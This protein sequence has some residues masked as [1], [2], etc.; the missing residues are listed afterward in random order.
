MRS[1]VGEGEGARVGGGEALQVGYYTVLGGTKRR[2]HDQQKEACLLLRGLRQ[3][4]V[5]LD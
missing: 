1:G 4:F 5:D 3:M 2:D